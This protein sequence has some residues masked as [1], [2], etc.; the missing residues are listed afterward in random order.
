[1]LEAW[2]LGRGGH[3]GNGVLRAALVFK[4]LPG[5]DWRGGQPSAALPT[6]SLLWASDRGPGHL[7]IKQVLG[8]VLGRLCVPA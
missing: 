3:P 2:R 6:S 8:S 7:G 1:M 5:L 4:L